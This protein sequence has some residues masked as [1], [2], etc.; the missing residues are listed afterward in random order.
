MWNKENNLVG[1]F[2]VFVA[3]RDGQVIGFVV[4]NM[5]DPHDNIDNI[6]VAKEEQRKDVGKNLVE[7]VE[8]IAKSRGFD[9]MT[10][11]TTENVR[12][13]AWKA[14]C[15]W[16]KMGYE[17]TGER[18]STDYGFKVISLVKRLK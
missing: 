16:K 9:T 17:D 11:D 14:Y 8:R 10:T 6:V 13:V 4:L 7:Y 18:L 15:F 3:E 5:D 12:G 2:E 1:G